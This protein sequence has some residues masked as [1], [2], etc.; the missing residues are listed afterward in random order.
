MQ[1]ARA[2]IGLVLSRGRCRVISGAF[3]KYDCQRQKPRKQAIEGYSH[4]SAHLI[5][6]DSQ[7]KIC[8]L[9]LTKD[10][11]LRRDSKGFFQQM[12][13]EEMWLSKT[14]G[15]CRETLSRLLHR[16]TFLSIRYAQRH[17]NRLFCPTKWWRPESESDKFFM[18]KK[19][20]Q[21]QFAAL[22]L[23]QSVVQD[24]LVIPA[25]LKNNHGLK[26]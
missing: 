2:S 4:R 15:A 8:L 23:R 11:R 5:T 26:K 16:L 1:W 12:I 13:K 22:N 10:K 7:K 21:W 14:I 19:P 18:D 6:K 17:W 9:S 25:N 3:A 24:A 20:L